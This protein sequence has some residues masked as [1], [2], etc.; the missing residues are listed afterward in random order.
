MIDDEFEAVDY[1]HDAETID[2]ADITA[3]LTKAS[4]HV[5]AI[6]EID[7]ELECARA[8]FRSEIDRLNRSLAAEVAKLE[9]R[10]AWHT[11]PVV[12]LHARILETNPKRKTIALPYGR[13]VARAQEPEYEIDDKAFVQWAS[14]H[15]PELVRYRIDTSPDRRALKA[16]PVV[17]G[18]VVAGERPVPGVV[19]TERPPKFS[20]EPPKDERPEQ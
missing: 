20:V 3:A 5:R 4:W 1:D 14:V 12:A 13:M 6:T 18:Q 7:F 15:Q 9:R 2:D 8:V 17:E 10:K 11:A 19:V 16:L